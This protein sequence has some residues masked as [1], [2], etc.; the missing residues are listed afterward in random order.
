MSA[1]ADRERI[2]QH[3]DAAASSYERHAVIQR[4]AAEQ[5]VERIATLPLPSRPRILE[6]G[7]GTGLLTRALACRLGEADWTI[8]D[9]APTMLAT[10]RTTGAPP[11][12]VRYQIMDGEHPTNLPGGYDLI[13][14]SMATQWFEDLNAGLGRLAHL[15]A[16]GG[17][18]AISTLALDTFREWRTAHAAA[19]LT[20]ATQV[21]P[22]PHTI[23]PT[24]PGLLGSVIDTH[25]V[26]THADGLQFL[27]HLRGVGAAIPSGTQTPLGISALRRVLEHFNA[28]GASVTYHIAQGIW[29]S[30]TTLPR[31]VFVTGTDTGIGKTLVSAVLAQAWQADYWKPLQS[32]LS[33]ETGDT[34][35][36]AQLAALRPARLHAPAAALQASLSPMAAAELEGLAIDTH[37]LTL[38]S[39]AAP[40]VVEGAGGLYVPIDE[41]H[42]MIDLIV[43]LG[44]PAVLVARSS[45]G[46][47]NHTLLSLR[48][49]RE[50]HIPVLGVVLSGTANPGNRKAIEHFGKVRIL[51]EIPAL[52]QVDAAVVEALAADIPA[53]EACLATMSTVK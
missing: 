43:Q 46:T 23:A 26:D 19:G 31:G 22:A 37:A 11:G 10:L 18:L 12:T 52:S 8:T 17:F 16:P 14:S 45:L 20:A 13:C 36:V 51:A 24:C 38:P 2:S 40:L 32:G 3:F 25:L 1:H 50:R 4:Q 47:I 7:C 49:L 29:Q 21:Y 44:L 48:A 30:P 53:L 15:L 33:D 6:I 27:K 35:T 42:M 39:T 5:L 41:E 9:I 34:D 28:Q